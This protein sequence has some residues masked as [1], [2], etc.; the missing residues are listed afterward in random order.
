MENKL[1]TE[2]QQLTVIDETEKANKQEPSLNV[3]MIL[4]NIE[5]LL[6]STEKGAVLHHKMAGYL[7]EIKPLLNNPDIKIPD[8]GKEILNKANDFV[9]KRPLTTL[10]IAAGAGVLLALLAGHKK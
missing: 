6:T 2:T 7:D 9:Q 8:K 3:L 5:K 4:D 10:G 1:A